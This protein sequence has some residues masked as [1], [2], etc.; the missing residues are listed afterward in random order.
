MQRV[1]D[2]A[3]SNLERA[4]ELFQQAA[5]ELRE[6]GQLSAHELR[7]RL[8]QVS[9]QVLDLLEREDEPRDL[10]AELDRQARAI[11]DDLR[12]VEELLKRK[13]EQQK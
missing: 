1:Q 9:E 3:M 2:E 10:I 5:R 12:R 13:R 11:A 8:R 4:Y 6:T 7:A